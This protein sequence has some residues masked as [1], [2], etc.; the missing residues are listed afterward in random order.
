MVSLSTGI[1]LCG[2]YPLEAATLTSASCSRADVGDAVNRANNGDTILIPSGRCTWTTNLTIKGKY[3]TL[4]GA[5]IDQTV[6]T[7]GI[8]KAAFPNI[9]QVLV[10]KTV[11]GGLT[12][13]AGITFTGGTLP[14]VNNKGMVLIEG[15]SHSFRIDHCKFIP[16]QTSAL[17]V[18]GDLWGVV[19]HNV[20]DLSANHGY[21]IYVQGAGY[22]DASWAVGSTL[23]TEQNVFVEDNIFS[24]D[25]SVGYFYPAQDGWSG[26]RIVVRYNTFNA[27]KAANH[28]TETGHRW[29]GARQYEYYNNTWTLDMQGNNEPA[30]ISIRGGTGVI[31][32]NSATVT[33]GKVY[34]FAEFKYFRFW[35]DYPTWGK[36]PSVWDRGPDRCLDQ[37]GV[38]QGLLLSGTKPTPQ[39]WPQQV[40]DPAYVWNNKINGTISNPISQTPTVVRIGRDI[41]LSPKPD[42]EPYTYPHPLTS[43]PEA[44][45]TQL[46]SPTDLTIK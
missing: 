22:G 5:G 40:D 35:S 1:L 43:S 14:D 12:R 26:H 37:T 38:G 4:R 8:S 25:Q 2:A 23:G 30:A 20:F 15:T 9:Q 11:A 3:L 19:D 7:D 41:I 24:Q 44:T 17:F 33:N 28:G 18:I 21:G 16:S 29:R 34:N 36:C 39:G 6:I 42:Y 46:T 31:Y 27:T 10:W 45:P 13:V 32:N